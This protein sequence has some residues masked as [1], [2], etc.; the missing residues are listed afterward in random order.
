MNPG[1][2]GIPFA[3][4]NKP[5]EPPQQS[6][7]PIIPRP[8]QAIGAAELDALCNSEKVTTV[9]GIKII[10]ALSQH[11]DVNDLSPKVCCRCCRWEL[12]KDAD[13]LAYGDLI[14]R[15]LTPDGGIEVTWEERVV[16]N[17]G[18]VV[19]LTYLEYVRIS[20]EKTSKIR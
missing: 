18:L 9:N 3:R 11:P 16:E 13:R 4:P 14:A 19:Y 2:V 15:S 5:V 10:G 1:E 8:L 17:G 7:P 12:S 20:D 6:G